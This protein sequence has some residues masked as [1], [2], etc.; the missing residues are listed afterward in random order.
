[1]IDDL[2]SSTQ[3]IEQQLRVDEAMADIHNLHTQAAL[4]ECAEEFYQLIEVCTDTHRDAVDMTFIEMGVR[5]NMLN[6]FVRK[7]ES[8]IKQ[9]KQKS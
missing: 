4:K 6:N 7:L 8:K 9:V 5:V 3:D 2:D 1:M